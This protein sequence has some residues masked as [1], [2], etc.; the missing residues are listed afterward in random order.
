MLQPPVADTFWEPKGTS[1][2]DRRRVHQ[3]RYAA[4]FASDQ[5]HQDRPVHRVSIQFAGYMLQLGSGLDSILSSS[6]WASC[7]KEISL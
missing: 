1:V 5:Q 7:L 6:F 2:E 3:W 4:D